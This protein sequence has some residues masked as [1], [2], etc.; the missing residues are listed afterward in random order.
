MQTLAII[1]EVPPV[2]ELLIG[3]PVANNAAGG[4]STTWTV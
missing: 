4:A 2:T 1:R 3:K